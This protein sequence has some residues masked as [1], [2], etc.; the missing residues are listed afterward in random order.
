MLMFCFGSL[1]SSFLQQLVSAW[2]L[3]SHSGIWVWL[4]V[5]AWRSK[6][7]EWKKKKKKYSHASKTQV[8]RIVCSLRRS[9]YDMFVIYTITCRS[10]WGVSLS[11]CRTVRVG[12]PRGFFTSVYMSLQGLLIL[13]DEYIIKF[14]ATYHVCLCELICEMIYCIRYSFNFQPVR[15]EIKSRF[16]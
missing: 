10:C 15:A 2:Y 14:V 8:T 6:E 4:N 13:P 7:I 9:G 1:Y 5:N 12:E 16:T 3:N 11:F